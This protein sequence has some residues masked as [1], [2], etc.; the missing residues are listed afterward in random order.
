[1]IFENPSSR[2]RR[3]S[4]LCLAAGL[5]FLVVLPVGSSA[6]ARDDPPVLPALQVVVL[7]DESGSLSDADVVREREAAQTIAFSVLAPDSVVS[8]VGFGS[9][10]GPGQ[11]AVD[12]VCRPTVLSRAQDQDSLA[13]CISKLHRRTPAEGADTDHAA[14]LQQALSFVQAGRPKRKVVFLLTD[15]VL[16]VSHSPNYGDTAD[17]RNAAAKAKAREV[18]N[19]L[20]RAGAQVWPFGFGTVKPALQDFA[21]GKSCTPAA[22]DPRAR[23]VPDSAKL[24]SAVAEA[25]SS[26]GCVKYGTPDVGD[27]PRGGSTDLHITI[28][29]IASDASILV[30]KR[31]PRVQVEYR[32]PDADR[33]APDEGG[34]KFDFA[35]Q[36]T[37]TESVRITDPQP[38]T[39]TIRLSSA[40][41]AAK[42]VAATVVYQAAVK[43]FLSVDP[44]QP[45][46]GQAVTVEMQVWARNQPIVDPQELRGLTFGTTLTGDGLPAEH[47]QL[48]DQDGDGTFSGTIRVPSGVAGDLTF[49]GVVSGVGI[50]GDTRILSTRVQAPGAVV[51]AQILFDDNR[52]TVVPGGTVHGRIV[53]Q[54]DSGGAARLRLQIADPSRGATLTVD[55]PVVS[56]PAGSS[57]TPFTLRVGANSPLGAS[58]A[59]LRLVEDTDPTY[60]V[61]ERLF[62]TEVAPKP[63]IPD[64]MRWVLLA[65]AVLL[66]AVALFVAFRLRSRREARRVDGLTA[67]LY[68]AGVLVSELEPDDPRANV[69][70]FVVYSDFTGLQLQH[71]SPGEPGLYEVRRARSGF[72]VAADGK[73]IRTL[74]PGERRPIGD[75]RAIA[76]VDGPDGAS[77]ADVDGVGR[78]SHDPF[79]EAAP[80]APG[81]VPAPRAGTPAGAARDPFGAAVKD[82]FADSPAPSSPGFGRRDP[83]TADP[84]AADSFAA[85]SFD[86]FGSGFDGPG[87]NGRDPS[88]VPPSGASA[89][90]D[91]DNHFR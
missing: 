77:P 33:P 6:I 26:A 49:A 80:E 78:V 76:V 69:F 3:L 10:N 39:W 23:V 63:W 5:G 52:A 45:A 61:A 42:D 18:L 1:M 44:P 32:A 86:P 88:G 54:N 4:A 17:R 70:R 19:D 15:G 40:D 37:A 38:G 20:D 50:G 83:F 82:P 51:R 22:P 57:T 7:V 16:D 71:A 58:S 48:A 75:D 35:G 56:A 90:P 30:Y 28:P 46:E 9:S 72:S 68:S 12:V 11:S 27:V 66:V 24:T 91:P 29:A 62:A 36:S 13:T 67:R 14:A 34:S 25:F 2:G 53:V 85:D 89:H 87:G 79:A 59:R 73:R 43:A 81:P 31:D 84:F 41:V 65:A 55:Q 64:W 60:A 8:V 74:S 21:R 47:V